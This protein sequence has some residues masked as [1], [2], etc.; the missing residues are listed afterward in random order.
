MLGWG[1]HTDSGVRANGARPVDPLGGGDLDGVDVLP[2]ALVT[3]QLGLVQGVQSLGQSKAER[4]RPSTPP[5]RLPR[6]RT[7]PAR[8]EWT[9]TAPHGRK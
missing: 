2:R 3:D 7:G 9:G 6:S 8:S 5:R 1:S 4:S